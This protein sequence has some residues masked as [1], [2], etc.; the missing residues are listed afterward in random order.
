MYPRYSDDGQNDRRLLG[1]QHGHREDHGP[2]E[3]RRASSTRPSLPERTRSTGRAARSPTERA[4]Y[5]DA[6]EGRARGRA[7]QGEGDRGGRRRLARRRSSTSSRAAGSV[8]VASQS[9]RRAESAGG[10]PDRAGP[11]GDPGEPDRDLRDLVATR[12]DRGV[13]RPPGR[14]TAFGSRRRCLRRKRL[15]L[16]LFSFQ[17]VSM[18]QVKGR[19]RA[20]R[21]I[22][23]RGHRAHG[24]AR[25]STSSSSGSRTSSGQ[26][27]SFA[28]TVQELEARAR[29]RDGLRRL[30][31]HGLQ[32]DRG[33]RHGRDPGP[34]DVPGP[35]LEHGRVQGRPHDLRHRHARREA[36]RG[37]PALRAER[38]L[39]RMR[40]MGFDTFNVGPELEYFYFE[41]DSGTARARPRRL[42]RP[43]RR[44]TWPSEWRKETIKALE[45]MGIPRRVRPPRGRRPPSTRSTC[46]TPRRST[47]PT[48]R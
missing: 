40:A 37:R 2:G 30:V 27:K 17:E 38:A 15:R 14:Y 13:R 5:Q 11:A 39:E 45:S 20:I 29:R 31:D 41:N 24:G 44:S 19:Q 46:A 23:K 26:L 48:T 33:V 34:E 8:P 43:R 7:R 1:G 18:A 4:L 32:P 10:R 47:W 42:L 6:L 28:V 25:G 12:D 3:R 22:G 16:G 9:R 36:V 35:A 21:R